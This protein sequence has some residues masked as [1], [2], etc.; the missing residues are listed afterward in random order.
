MI[1]DPVSFSLFPLRLYTDWII[2]NKDEL[3]RM[4][5]VVGLVEHRRIRDMETIEYLR[6]RVDILEDRIPETRRAC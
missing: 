4:K 1:V 5:G 3:L 2:R 6:R